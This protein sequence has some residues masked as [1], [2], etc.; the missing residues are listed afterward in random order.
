MNNTTLQ[1]KIKQR[2]NKLAS[3]DYDNIECWQIV[4]AFN[5]AQIQWVRRQLIG[6]NAEKQGDEQTT[7]KID[8]LQNLLKEIPIQVTQKQLYVESDLLPSD[9]LQFKRINAYGKKDCCENPMDLFV[10]YLAEEENVPILLQNDLKKPSFEWGETFCTL[11]GDKVRIYNNNEFDVVDVSLMYYREPLKI[12]IQNCVD[13]Y[14]LAT[15]TA[16]VECEFQD[17]I[18]EVLIDNAVQV[19]AGDIESMNQ[20]SIANNSSE[21]NT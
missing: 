4:E 21:V 17:N 10:G 8:D 13:P 16:D 1:L 3:N 14:T 6:M 12:Q 11:V 18:V 5:K 9:Y 2:L 20:Y 19:L 15:S 7:R